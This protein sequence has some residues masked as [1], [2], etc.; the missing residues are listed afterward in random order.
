MVGANQLSR[1]S[2]GFFRVIVQSDSFEQV[3]P[4]I[5]LFEQSFARIQEIG[6]DVNY[7]PQAVFIWALDILRNAVPC[8]AAFIAVRVGDVFRIEASW[9][10]SEIANGSEISIKEDRILSE[11]IYTRQGCI[12]SDIQKPLDFVINAGLQKPTRSCMA[13][14]ITLG[15]RVIGLFVC[16]SHHSKGFVSSD[17]IQSQG[18]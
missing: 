6:G 18:Y 14:P 16:I 1:E 4:E 13:L 17:L 5:P 8:D 11:M 3:S 12:L 9:N 7:K 10:Y 15:R 2:Q